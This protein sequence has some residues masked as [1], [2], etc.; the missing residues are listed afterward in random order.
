[1]G[2]PS[3]HARRGAFKSEPQFS[4]PFSFHG[5]RRTAKKSGMGGRKVDSRRRCG[6]SHPGQHIGAAKAAG[7]LGRRQQRGDVMLNKSGIRELPPPLPTIRQEDRWWWSGW[8]VGA[9]GGNRSKPS[10]SCV[11]C[12]N[13]RTNVCGDESHIS[14]QQQQR[15][16]R[17]SGT[18]RGTPCWL[19]GG[20]G[21]A[22]NNS[23]LTYTHE[24]ERWREKGELLLRWR[25]C[26]WRWAFVA[27]G[28]NDG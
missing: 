10:S 3:L 8:L 13:E 11:M 23:S 17:R 2:R 9:E 18:K 19:H 25:C 12:T 1:M 28:N 26:R 27:R 21:T 5:V 16:K 6:T 14:R 22:S 7:F 4:L 15:E 20:G 24:N